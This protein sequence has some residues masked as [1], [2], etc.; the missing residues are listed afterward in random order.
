MFEEFIT[1]NTT[2]S[3][4]QKKASKLI[5]DFFKSK[6]KYF[7]LFGVAGSGKTWLISNIVNFIYP[8]KI[9]Q[10]YIISAPTNQAIKNLKH[11]F[12]YKDIECKT[13]HSVLGIKATYNHQDGDKVFLKKTSIDVLPDK[14]LLVIDECSMLSDYITKIIYKE[15]ADFKIIFLGDPAQL[16][17]VNEES[18][19]CI[20]QG[21]ISK[22]G[23][24]LTEIRR[25]KNEMIMKFSNYIRSWV[26]E[27]SNKLS[28]Y[29]KYKSENI[30]FYHQYDNLDQ[31]TWMK[32]LINNYQ[33]KK[34]PFIILTWTNEARDN[35]NNYIRKKLFNEQS[36]EMFLKDEILIMDNNY[37]INNE[38]VLRTSNQIRILEVSKC[39]INIVNRLNIYEEFY[40]KDTSKYSILMFE[41]IRKIKYNYFMIFK[42]IKLKILYESKIY[43]IYILDESEFEKRDYLANNLKNDIQELSSLPHYYRSELWAIH[44]DLYYQPFAEVSY[45]YC[46]TVH[47]AQSATYENTYIDTPNILLNNRLME[48]KSCLYTAITRT[49]NNLNMII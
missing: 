45:G 31:A 43:E 2:L 9:F 15:N 10:K 22:S 37:K 36:K 44:N 42:V 21:S 11:I 13:V 8:K 38:Y 46:I 47:K 26:F 23:Y 49:A 48:A 24:M 27:K 39:K 28:N 12:P 4:D 40:R 14:L 17:P 25:T 41:F 1:A 29:L 35:Y 16:P 3:E 33:S 34:E 30:K 7:Y 32:K 6:E 19:S 18:N 20:M 5:F